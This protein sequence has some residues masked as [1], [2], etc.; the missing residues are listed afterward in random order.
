M[1]NVVV[2]NAY[3]KRMIGYDATEV[4]REY[5]YERTTRSPLRK[6]S[7]PRKTTPK[8]T[9]TALWASIRPYRERCKECGLCIHHCPKDAIRKSDHLN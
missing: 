1:D 4:R 3:L 9:R 2:T 6:A 7:S 8:V 5:K